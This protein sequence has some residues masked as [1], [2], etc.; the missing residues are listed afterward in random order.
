MW[1]IT[2]F[3]DMVVLFGLPD[4][5]AM[6]DKCKDDILLLT[7]DTT[8]LRMCYGETPPG[9]HGVSGYD[10][11][12]TKC[13]LC[14]RPCKGRRGLQAHL[15]ACMKRGPDRITASPRK[16]VGS[17]KGTDCVH[18]SSGGVTASPSVNGEEVSLNTTLNAESPASQDS[19]VMRLSS[20]AMPGAERES[21]PT[22]VGPAWIG[23][24]RVTRNF[25]Y[26]SCGS[27]FVGKRGLSQHER[28]AHAGDYHSGLAIGHRTGKKRRW[29]HDE[30]V[31]LAREEI[32]LCGKSRNLN[33]ELS[34]AFAD[35]TLE[36]IKGL[37]K[38]P[39]YRALVDKLCLEG[40][41]QASPADG[42]AGLRGAGIFDVATSIS[43]PDC[44][45]RHSVGYA[46]RTAG[47][48]PL[49]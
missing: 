35:Q 31:L 30:K 37:R 39:A 42:S 19:T 34:L 20:A 6:L 10:T 3:P 28:R 33:L 21:G 46:P 1:S 32:C 45:R 8:F 44:P 14:G 2:T 17:T 25:A 26:S 15:R 41:R 49:M 22:M 38:N 9:S 5:L 40:G 13:D 18:R 12:V 48:Q 11:G 43:E 27:S 24:A 47:G 16:S 23:N 4:F 7:Y 36:A 29:S